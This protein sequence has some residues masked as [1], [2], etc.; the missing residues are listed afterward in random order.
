MEI[1]NGM[2][3]KKFMWKDLSILYGFQSKVTHIKKKNFFYLTI[4]SAYKSRNMEITLKILA[5]ILGAQLAQTGL[6]PNSEE[7]NTEFQY[8]E[9]TIG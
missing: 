2:T 5:L 4:Q 3:K 7:S 8:K 6:L 9:R 1:W